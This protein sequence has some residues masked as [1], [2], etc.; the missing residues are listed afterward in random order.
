MSS[1]ATP[2]TSP[3]PA[4]ASATSSPARANLAAP[5]P[6]LVTGGADPFLAHL[7]P[8]FAT[9]AD[10]AIVAAFVQESGLDLLQ[11]DVFA[12][13]ARDARIRVLTGDYLD[14]TQAAALERL[15]DW[16]RTHP[17]FEARVVET[18]PLGAAF[19]PKSWRFDGTAFV[20]SSN[21]SRSALGPGVEWNLR[22]DRA[23]DPAAF[24]ALTA[25]FE[26]RYAAARPLD[27][28]YVSDYA[29]RA[30]PRPLP[31]GEDEAVPLE[32]PP[33]P[34][35]LQQEALAALAATRAAGRTRA[36]VVLATGLG[37]T[38][39]AALD[40]RAYLEAHPTARVLL[41][42]RREEL[43]AQAATTFRRVLRPT[44]PGLT[45]GFFVGDDSDLD[46]D[47]VVASV[48]KLSR[49]ADRLTPHAF[50]YVIVDEV[51]HATAASYRKLLDRLAPR[52]LLGLTATPDRADGGDVAGL[53]DDHVPY[54]ADL[55]AGIERGLLVPFAYFG[56]KD[57]LDY[58]HVPWRNRR[59]DPEVLARAAQTEARMETLHRA[60]HAH[61]AARTLVFCCSIDHATFAR[62]WLR[63]KGVRV[64][65]VHSGPGSFDRDR[66]LD[67]L[68]DGA[69]DALTTVDLFNEGI[70]LRELD[71]VVML[72][73][74]ESGVVF[75]QQLG[76]GLRTHAD[77]ARLTV[78]DFVGNHRVFLERV[79][80]LLDLGERPTSIRAFLDGGD[81]ELPPGCA[82][83]LELEAKDLLAK[84]LPAGGRAVEDAFRELLAARGE[85]PTAGELYRLGH[86]PA[87]L[88]GGWF[89]FLAEQGALT[90]AEGRVL[91]A[92]RPWLHELETTHLTKSF[93]LVLLEA[94][95][96]AGA[97]GSGL[98]L[99]ELA[100]RSKALLD[101]DPA[102][103]AEV[104]TT[105]AFL[106]YWN[107]NPV[108]AWTRSAF[109]AREG[110]RFVPRLPI[111]P[112]DE[113]TFAAMTR[114]LVDYRL[115]RYRRTAAGDGF[116]AKVI[117]SQRDPILS[118]P[119][120]RRP[121]GPTDVRLPDGRIFQFDFA[122]VA[123]NK[124][125]PA[126]T[127]RNQLPDLLRR[128]FGPTAGRPGT[129][130]HVRFVPSPDG[131]WIEPLGPVAAPARGRVTA[132]PDLRAA[133]GAATG[134][135]D[136]APGAEPVR[137]P[138]PA[139]PDTFAVRAAGRS[140]DGGKAPIRD[141]D[142][143]VFRYARGAALGAALGKVALVQ[144]PDGSGHAYQVKR[145][146]RAGRGFELRSDNPDAPSYPATSDTVPIAL[147][148][149]TVAPASL[150]PPAGTTLTEAGARKAFGATCTGRHD[151]HLVVVSERFTAPDRLDA[152]VADR[153]PGETAFVLVP[154][155]DGFRYAGVG[156]W[157]ED[158]RRWETPAL[159]FATWRALGGR[160][161]SRR[162]P[163]GAE[164]A[165]R[166]LA[167][168][169]AAR[170]GAFVGRGERRCRIAG[171]AAQGGVRI[172]GGP[173][174]F[175]AR[176][177]SIA[178]LGW[179]LH[180]REHAAAPDEALVNRL[181]YLEG[182]PKGSTR[183]IDTGWALV[184]AS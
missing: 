178:D 16:Q 84:L 133:A 35:D 103:A 39:L 167:A 23:K 48:Q 134:A 136:E 181:R 44:R 62:D 131:L 111:P 164:T 31:P 24:A 155:E 47:L 67:A 56:V 149:A 94:L 79:R 101:R 66:A 85:R 8:L 22:L 104:E 32:P 153:R 139:D 130:F 154:R 72:R 152:A 145:V 57:D 1:P 117:W 53:F 12:A 10:I 180:A 70:D 177:V 159:D 135:R 100:A 33:S 83:E 87:A 40:V 82:V 129:A 29:K 81:P 97:L 161:V 121:H 9:A 43:L 37:K 147:H 102:L 88:R 141:G 30:R 126:G 25:A 45:V 163:A 75:L 125:R 65:A 14:I 112:G 179:V 143:L 46:G 13:L 90:G 151:G 146:V 142:W 158:E 89:D 34:H 17:R 140:M 109:F 170:A 171:P 165:A 73:P 183:W 68:R 113:E 95:L 28:A 116:T 52:F 19:H 107:R 182:T 166:A 50:D 176:T 106:P 124:A 59:F 15:L 86:N 96:E 128:W 11:P 71:R 18:K 132:F 49:H 20:G 41:L 108:D 80:T 69:L 115:V 137:L 3:I 144:T 58:E 150:A 92:A 168:E 169:L 138:V 27:A 175:G 4:A 122:K 6:A 91:A 54:R 173:G 162:L 127:D 114:E 74:T 172:D 21:V 38:I 110:D 120:T 93:K 7:R 26:H 156:R 60:W 123:V 77:K 105:G 99:A 118:L 78:I 184:L 5:A 36:L 61:P 119:R 98:P 148:V 64:E 160:T 76:R 2:A 157:L 55:G 174:G 42:A 63:S 51:H